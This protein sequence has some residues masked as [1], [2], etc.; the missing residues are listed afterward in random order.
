MPA[1]MSGTING[2]ITINA[3][4]SKPPKASQGTNFWLIG[5][6]VMGKFVCKYLS[7]KLFLSEYILR[8]NNIYF[9]L[10]LLATEIRS[11]SANI[12]PENTKVK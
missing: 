9:L 8:V 7:L 6:R 3:S 11:I 4:N 10:E 12:T 5:R 2:A 1:Q